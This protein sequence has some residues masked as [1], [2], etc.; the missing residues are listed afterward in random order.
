MPAGVQRLVTD[1]TACDAQR[2]LT[3]GAC[4]RLR[5]LLGHGVEEA[6]V[7]GSVTVRKRAQLRPVMAPMLDAQTRQSTAQRSLTYLLTYFTALQRS[8]DRRP[9]ANTTQLYNIPNEQGISEFGRERG[10]NIWIRPNE[11]F[12]EN[13]CGALRARAGRVD[14]RPNPKLIF[15]S[16]SRLPQAVRRST[17]RART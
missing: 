14:G 15:S 13:F 7:T 3:C 4:M 8:A 17:H 1:P 2:R 11:H 10:R 16:R 12:R 5:P 6:L 9:C